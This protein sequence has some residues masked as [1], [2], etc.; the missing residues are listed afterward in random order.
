VST[1]DSLSS[2][3][4]GGTGLPNSEILAE[5]LSEISR[6]RT[7]AEVLRNPRPSQKKS[8]PINDEDLPVIRAYLEDL[9]P[10]VIVVHRFWT[11]AIQELRVQ[12]PQLDPPIPARVVND[13]YRDKL[14]TR[15][16]A[17][18]WDTIREDPDLAYAPGRLEAQLL[19]ESHLAFV[20][21]R[22]FEP[23]TD[24][25]DELDVLF[26]ARGST[27]ERG[28]NQPVVLSNGVALPVTRGEA[29][30][31]GAVRDITRRGKSGL[32][33]WL[34]LTD[35]ALEDS[36]AQ[37]GDYFDFDFF[38]GDEPTEVAVTTARASRIH[39]AGLLNEYLE[40]TRAVISTRVRKGTDTDSQTSE[41]VQAE[42]VRRFERAAQRNWPEAGLLHHCITLA[43][44]NYYGRK[45][46]GTRLL[47]L[48]EELDGNG[49]TEGG[50]GTA[51]SSASRGL[52]PSEAG[53]LID[54]TN[55]LE[56]AIA[57]RLCPRC[58]SSAPHDRTACSPAD[59]DRTLS[60]E[61]DELG[62]VRELIRG[63]NSMHLDVLP[64]LTELDVRDILR[65]ITQA[66]HP[67]KSRDWCDRRASGAGNLL[68]QLR[69]G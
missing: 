17:L 64:T 42:V 21:E 34:A 55:A 40:S 7:L 31:F 62:T 44:V 33:A 27:R 5:L 68:R 57:T 61:D 50:T 35:T 69:Y 24:P 14:K 8:A 45:E 1:I 10:T 47:P 13:R 51:E 54:I 16:K 39:A 52:Q 60:R 59:S 65:D 22:A 66:R 48:P 4:A 49:H 25:P 29:G 43:L 37:F 46:R 58:S 2:E 30:L 63:L 6:E 9:L 19:T 28:A 36:V 23:T 41:P 15:S 67:D 12:G 20:L 18:F 53:G 11:L 32:P 38:F 56:A 26:L 3:L